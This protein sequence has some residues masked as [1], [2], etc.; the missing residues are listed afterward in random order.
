MNEKEKKV[1]IVRGS[2]GE[3][4][5]FCFWDVSAFLDVKQARKLKNKLNAWLRK[6]NAHFYNG[7]VH[8]RK[9][10]DNPNDPDMYVDYTGAEY[11]VIEVP[12]KQ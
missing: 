12:L 8:I 7:T 3:Y 6:N 11:E 10:K 9:L 5:D 4:S 1:F 2:T